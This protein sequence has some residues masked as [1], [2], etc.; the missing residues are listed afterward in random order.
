[1]K[2]T[3]D[4]KYYVVPV[5][6]GFAVLPFDEDVCRHLNPY[7]GPIL[8]AEEAV[9]A[10]KGQDVSLVYN[11]KEWGVYWVRGENLTVQRLEN[12]RAK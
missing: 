9:V 12:V 10:A 8:T 11:V 7:E 3:P 6:N 2:T 4:P 1:M 5:K